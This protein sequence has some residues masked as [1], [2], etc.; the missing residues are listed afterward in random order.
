MIKAKTEEILYKNYDEYFSLINHFGMGMIIF[1]SLVAEL[2]GS[3]S[4]VR[5]GGLVGQDQP[6]IGPNVN[7]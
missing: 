3:Y 6:R 7:A 5:I 1:P 2:Q 4:I